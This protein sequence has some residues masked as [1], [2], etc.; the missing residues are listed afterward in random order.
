[1]YKTYEEVPN[2]KEHFFAIVWVCSSLYYICDNE[3]DV[4]ECLELVKNEPE[5][6]VLKPVK[7]FVF[8]KES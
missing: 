8:G 2:S 3:A 4:Q 1:M 6:L 5:V 7:K